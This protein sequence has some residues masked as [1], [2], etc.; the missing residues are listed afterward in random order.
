MWKVT[1]IDDDDKVLRGM[2]NIIPWDELSCEWAGEARN[3]Q[4]GYELIKR[5]KPDLIITD[6]YMPVLNGLEMIKKLRNEGIDSRVIILSGYNEFE[7][8]RQAM[9]LNI[10]DYLSKP[11]SP[12]TIK[13]VLEKSVA[14]LEREISEEIEMC[15]LREKVSLYEPLVEKEWIKAIVTGASTNFTNLPLT[16][17]KITKKWSKQ[18]H[19]VM[20]LTYDRSL[21]ESS[22]YRSDWYLFRFTTNN[23]IKEAVHAFFD[24]IHY[25]ELH[26]HQTAICIHLNK[27]NN[28]DLKQSLEKLQKILVEK[29]QEYFQVHVLIS[30]GSIKDDWGNMADS[31]REAFAKISDNRQM[32]DPSSML[33]QNPEVALVDKDH[34]T[35]WSDSM[36]ANQQMSESIRYAD[37]KGAMAVIDRIYEQ[38]KHESFSR[39]EGIRLGIEMWTIMT[40]SLYDIGIKI[41]EMYSEEFD[42][43]AEL[44]K[45][46]TWIEFKDYMDGVVRHICEHQQW[47][48]N[49]KHRQL[50]EQML[51][52]I[53]K[54]VGENITLQ[55]IAD[56]LFISRNY[57]GQIFKKIVGESFK[58]YLTR[59]RMEKAKKMIQEGSYLI[60]EISE[61]VGFINPAYFTTTFKKYTGY[62]PTEL[63]NR[64]TIS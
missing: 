57:L 54:N 23:V 18:K 51:D 33:G 19:V 59:V 10:D 20:T 9:R 31:M 58:N 39:G 55:D 32:N 34:K 22:F 26:S 7:Y 15:D 25:I 12:D 46:N 43:H 1:I 28:D 52:Y 37:E 49:L 29:F 36:E 13:E 38:N 2:K 14:K 61:K 6:I 3:G 11:A 63:I 27:E 4:E 21:E 53:Q 64:R 41:D 8:A 42:F 17:D 44:L 48:E 35:L 56:D 50:V 62:T 24:D 30:T 5:E 60:Y 40:Y 16:V 45:T 47:D